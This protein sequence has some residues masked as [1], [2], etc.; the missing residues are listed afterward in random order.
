MATSKGSLKRHP[1]NLLLDDDEYARLTE[2]AKADRRSRVNYVLVVLRRHLFTKDLPGD[3]GPL[4]PTVPP[5]K[6]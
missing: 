2:R 3:V 4:S 1:L 5:A 6:N